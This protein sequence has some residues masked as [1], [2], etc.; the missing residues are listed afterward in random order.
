MIEPSFFLLLLLLMPSVSK[1][2]LMSVQYIRNLEGS[3]ASIVLTGMYGRL[4]LLWSFVCVSINITDIILCCANHEHSL[5]SRSSLAP[6]TMQYRTKVSTSLR[7][8]IHRN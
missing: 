4:C 7:R 1:P 3:R 6:T 8:H 5:F 2:C